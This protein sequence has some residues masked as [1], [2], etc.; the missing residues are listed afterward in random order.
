MVF[1]YLTCKFSCYF[2]NRL[3]VRAHRVG[4]E[5]GLG[6]VW[7]GSWY[8]NFT[9]RT[10]A[11]F[12][13]EKFVECATRWTWKSNESI[14]FLRSAY[15]IWNRSCHK[16]YHKYGS[17]PDSRK[18]NQSGPDTRKFDQSGPGPKILGPDGLYCQ[19]IIM[20]F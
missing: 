14:L 1:F 11:S 12:H 16:E 10:R 3:S 4:S 6:R 13:F 17:S 7:A 20:V 15:Q 2:T 19:L 9:D 5:T 8:E 18:I